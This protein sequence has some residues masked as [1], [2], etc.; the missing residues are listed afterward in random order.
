MRKTRIFHF[1]DEINERFGCSYV[2]HAIKFQR[3]D[4]EYCLEIAQYLINLTTNKKREQKPKICLK[5]HSI[6]SQ[7]N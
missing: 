3:I 2:F 5:I 7:N 4:V 1:N 6:M